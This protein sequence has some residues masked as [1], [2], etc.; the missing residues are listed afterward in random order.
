MKDIK[1]SK[2]TKEKYQE[3]PQVH[4]PSMQRQY[5]KIPYVDPEGWG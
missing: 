1:D 4:R 5:S 2:D 3:L